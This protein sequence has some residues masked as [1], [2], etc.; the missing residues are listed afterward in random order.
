MMDYDPCVGCGQF[1][2]LSAFPCHMCG[3][4]GYFCTA[5]CRLS[6][7]DNHIDECATRMTVIDNQTRM[8]P[9]SVFHSV[10]L[11]HVM[12]GRSLAKSLLELFQLGELWT[13]RGAVLLRTNDPEGICTLMKYSANPQSVLFQLCRFET[14][15]S[16]VERN[17]DHMKEICIARMRMRATDEMVEHCNRFLFSVVSGGSV[18]LCT[19]VTVSA[20]RNE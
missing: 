20:K 10:V 19:P 4:D 2:V 15:A 9:R 1:E 11:T 12:D 3:N 16:L 5:S 8:T 18:I 14:C 7:F 13:G 6:N 17:Y